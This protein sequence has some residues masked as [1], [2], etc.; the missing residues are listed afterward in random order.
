[1]TVTEDA[2]ATTEH[3]IGKARFRKEDE[4]LI[5]GRSRYTDDI[6]LPGMLHLAM[7][8]SPLAHAKVLSESYDVPLVATY[9]PAALLR[10]A[11]L[12]RPTWED[13]QLLR[14]IYDEAL[15]ARAARSG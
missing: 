8:R 14:R 3:E 13:V 4:R 7:V 1:M 12:K 15:E 6:K 5:T 10:N 11:S 9:H 2:P